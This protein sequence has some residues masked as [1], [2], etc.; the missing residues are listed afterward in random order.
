MEFCGI[1]EN[2]F[3]E[4]CF[5]LEAQRFMFKRPHCCAFLFGASLVFLALVLAVRVQRMPQHSHA[6]QTQRVAEAVTHLQNGCLTCHQVHSLAAVAF[7]PALT[8]AFDDQTDW[9]TVR[10]AVTPIQPQA[11]AQERLIDLGQRLLTLPENA[12][13][14]D[15]FL[16]TVNAVQ[17]ADGRDPVAMQRLFVHI[18]HLEA[19]LHVLE[20]Q[21]SPYQVK[22]QDSRSLPAHVAVVS[23]TPGSTLAALVAEPVRVIAA[24]SDTAQV[25]ADPRQY[26]R[27]L[28][29]V[30]ASQRHGPPAGASFDSG[31]S[32][33]LLT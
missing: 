8:H 1:L 10:L 29:I 24:G 14:A 22:T 16:R 4:S 20:N 25:Q 15:A 17:A 2:T 23:S 6:A 21:A 5:Y 31:W 3:S 27:A 9:Q 32:G 33:R 7:T 19:L 28:E 26:V 12:Q 11:R 18:D 30:F 13:A